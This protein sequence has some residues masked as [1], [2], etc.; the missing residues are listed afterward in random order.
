MVETAT[1]DLRQVATLLRRPPTD[2]DYIA[3]LLQHSQSA[4]IIQRLAAR[5]LPPE[6]AQAVLDARTTPQAAM[7]FAALFSDHVFP[8][9]L[10]HLGI[11]PFTNFLFEEADTDNLLHYLLN[12]ITYRLHGVDY[13]YE[14]HDHAPVP[15]IAVGVLANIFNVTSESWAY[16][17]DQ[18]AAHRAVWSEHLEATHDV[19]PEAIHRIPYF[20]H[21]LDDFTAAVAGT[22]HAMA[23]DCL[24]YMAQLH[25][26]IFLSWYDTEEDINYTDQW[27]DENIETGTAA[28]AEADR[29]L[30]NINL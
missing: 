3:D 11:D 16:H 19:P 1:L 24:I 23:N 20:G 7:T 17:R 13:A 6:H 29:I 12:A 28:W 9:F 2:L 26:N 10:E 22:E 25:D 8:L 18:A 27:T 21:D 5:H 4:S 15:L 30:R 14:L